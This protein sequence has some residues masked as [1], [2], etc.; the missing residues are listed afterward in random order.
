MNELGHSG[1]KS[2]SSVSTDSSLHHDGEHGTPQHSNNNTLRK[3]LDSNDS[4]GSNNSHNSS[5]RVT[6]Q[7]K[8]FEENHVN[9]A[10]SNYTLHE[11]TYNL[12]KGWTNVNSC[13]NNQN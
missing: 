13:C 3:R 5:P 8:P 11:V 4:I 2:V 6:R 10:T 1:R 12:P 7:I 9:F